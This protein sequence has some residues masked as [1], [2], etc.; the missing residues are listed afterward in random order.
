MDK[1][2]GLGNPTGI[3]GD[4]TGQ[5]HEV[6]SSSKQQSPPAVV[7]ELG[8]QDPMIQAEVQS[9]GNVPHLVFKSKRWCESDELTVL[10]FLVLLIDDQKGKVE[11]GRQ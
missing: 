11:R 5:T 9:P 1:K 10:V 2:K 8:R 6:A 3:K 4:Q 7:Q